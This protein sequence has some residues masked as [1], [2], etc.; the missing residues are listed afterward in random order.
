MRYNVVHEVYTGG[1]NIVMEGGRKEG[2]KVPK[3]KKDQ[4]GKGGGIMRSEV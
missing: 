2:G 3:N 1:N 4:N